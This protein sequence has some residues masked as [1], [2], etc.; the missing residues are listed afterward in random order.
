MKHSAK[1][2]PKNKQNN[3]YQCNKKNSD[4]A[5]TIQF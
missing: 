3:S 1:N 5:Q 2:T 4:A